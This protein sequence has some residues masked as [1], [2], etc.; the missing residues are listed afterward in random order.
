M[1][2]C[3]PVS[4]WTRA[5]R[6]RQG[7]GRGDRVRGSAGDLPGGAMGAPMTYMVDGKQDVALRVGGGSVPELIALP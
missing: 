7:D 5:G 4:A 3:R 6:A 2:G 1:V